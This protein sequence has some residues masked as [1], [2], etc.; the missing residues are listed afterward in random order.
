[1]ETL[2]GQLETLKTGHAELEQVKQKLTEENT[3]LKE[4]VEKQDEQLQELKAHQTQ[5]VEEITQLKFQIEAFTQQVQTLSINQAQLE[6]DKKALLDKNADQESQ[7]ADLK[8]QLRKCCSPRPHGLTV[9]WNTRQS[10]D[11]SWDDVAK[12]F[13]ITT[14]ELFRLNPE[15]NAST[16]FNFDKWLNV[17]SVTNPEGRQAN[18]T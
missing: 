10:D 11:R 12:R 7:I 4:Q 1:M 14:A 18:S 16:Q 8:D 17:P 6:Q 9:R 5:H 13:G 15:I 2:K 3:M